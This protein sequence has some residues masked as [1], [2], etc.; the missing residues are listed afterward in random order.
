MRCGAGDYLK[1]VKL[2][3]SGFRF[4]ARIRCFV[5]VPEMGIGQEFS[6]RSTPDPASLLNIAMF[7]LAKLGRS[8]FRFPAGVI[9]L[10]STRGGNR[11]HMPLRGRGF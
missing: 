4:P 10:F 11:T 5:Q 2:G 3:R 9:V 1:F 6:L 8:G 7:S